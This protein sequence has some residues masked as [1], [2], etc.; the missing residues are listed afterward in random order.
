VLLRLLV[1]TSSAPAV[2][3]RKQVVL[4]FRHNLVSA[5]S[6][7]HAPAASLSVQKTSA[8][9][10]ESPFSIQSILSLHAKQHIILS[11]GMLRLMKVKEF[12]SASS[13]EHLHKETFNSI[14]GQTTFFLF[15]Q[16]ERKL[17]MYTSS[18]MNSKP[19]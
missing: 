18:R 12:E 9:P 7:A 10:P 4:I 1:A 15:F 11:L 2:T 13:T 5:G 6:S 3:R 16:F 8:I 17:R 19:N 14:V